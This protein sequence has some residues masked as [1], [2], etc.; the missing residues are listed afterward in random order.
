MLVT[1]IVWVSR[2][3]AIRPPPAPAIAVTIGSSIASSEPNAMNSTTA[4]AST[5]TAEMTST[6]A[7]WALPM[8]GPPSWTSR[9]GDRAAS[10]V[11]IT[12][13]TS[14][15]TRVSACRVNWTVAY[16]MRPSRLICAAPRGLYGLAAAATSGIVA[17]CRSTPAIRL[18]TA[19][20]RTV[21]W[22]TR[23]T[24]VSESPACAGTASASSRCAVRPDQSA[25]RAHPARRAVPRRARRGLRPH[26]G[27]P[28]PRPPRREGSG[29]AATHRIR[30]HH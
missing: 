9:P 27:R 1:F 29:R 2:A 13:V 15:L 19:P 4:A 7:C 24:I 5:P 20:S 11:L 8:A 18:L 17:I 21:P 26:A 6:G 28:G 23:Q 3:I 14:V 22:L 25:G 30:Q 16:A 12:R 10:A